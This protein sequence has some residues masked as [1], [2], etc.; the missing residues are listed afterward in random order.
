[1]SD[2]G[3][4][5]IVNGA[6]VAWFAATDETAQEW[7]SENHFGEWLSMPA[8]TPNIIP[9]TQQQIDNAKAKGAELYAKLVLHP[10]SE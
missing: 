5:I 9:F 3:T 1:M 2:I 6:I 10:E 4:A 8:S 7:A